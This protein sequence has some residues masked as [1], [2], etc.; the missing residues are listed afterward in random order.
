MPT[1]SFLIEVCSCEVYKF[2]APTEIA[3]NTSVLSD[4]GTVSSEISWNVVSI[5][6]DQD[7]RCGENAVECQFSAAATLSDGSP[8]PAWMSFSDPTFT[9]DPLLATPADAATYTVS[10]EYSWLS[11]PGVAI[12]TQAITV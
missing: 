10:V 8:L 2:E 1:D 3:L 7:L 6:T 9:V 4:A 5:G 12:H 11:D